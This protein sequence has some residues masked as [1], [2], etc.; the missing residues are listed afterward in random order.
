MPA[1]ARASELDRALRCVGS[2][3][4]PKLP[5]EK[6]ASEK[7]VQAACWGTMC[8][9]WK[10]TGEIIPDERYPQHKFLFK[11]KLYTIGVVTEKD[12][13][14]F[15]EKWWPTGGLHEVSVALD[16]IGQGVAWSETKDANVWKAAFSE[17]WITGTLDYIGTRKGCPWVDDLKTGNWP[18][19]PAEK[20][21]QIRLYAL[22]AVRLL[23]PGIVRPNLVYMSI[24]HW[25][26][27]PL[28]KMPER[29]YHRVTPDHLL[30]VETYIRRR[31]LLRTA[32]VSNRAAGPNF[33]ETLKL[34]K[35][36]KFCPSRVYCPLIEQEEAD[37]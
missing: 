25:P 3:L 24:T 37:D 16:C 9:G 17:N 29:V 12:S 1:W 18:P 7:A 34:G 15:R 6:R 5:E 23:R 11:K 36:C 31:Y 10:E 27:Y 19:T 4:L 20:S 35:H 30:E 33:L 26:R 21:A 14:V 8:H 13:K 2:T 32:H 22:A 28:N